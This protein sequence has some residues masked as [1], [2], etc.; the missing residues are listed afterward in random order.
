MHTLIEEIYRNATPDVL[1]SAITPAKG[2]LLQKILANKNITRT[3]EI[4]CGNGLSS[5]Y[6]CEAQRGKKSAH[7]TILDPLETKEFAGAGIDNLLRAGIDFFTLAEEGSETALP[8]L[9]KQGAQFDFGLIDGF[10]TLDHTIVDIYFMTRL[11]R[12]GGYLVIDDVNAR[13]VNRAARYLATYPCY[14]LAGSVPYGGPRRRALNTVKRLLSLAIR[15]L[16]V[17]AGKAISF[18]FFDSSLLRP[19]VVAVLDSSSMVAFQKVAE[20]ERK[21][22]WYDFV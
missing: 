11:L 4:G 21:S 15:P 14:R 8:A 12:I 22:S 19:D 6:I 9:L 17:V 16:T 7:H 3:L 5:L 10:H 2:E 20:D 13:S 1:A 18:E